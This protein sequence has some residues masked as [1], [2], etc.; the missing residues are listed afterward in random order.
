MNS[1]TKIG[2]LTATAG[3]ALAMSSMAMAPGTASATRPSQG[4]HTVTICHRTNSVTNPYVVITVDEA[5][6]NKDAGDDRG[7]GDHNA[8]H[9]GPAFDPT[10]TYTPP[11]RGDEWGDIIPPFYSDGTTTG[12]WE[13]KNWPS[14]QAIFEN[15]CAPVIPTTTTAAPTSTTAAPTTTTD[16][17][18]DECEH[19]GDE[20]DEDDE[21]DEGDDCEEVTTTTAA[22]TTTTEAPT[23]TTEAPTTTVDAGGPT[24]TEAPT[25]PVEATTTTIVG[26]EGPTTTTLL[27]SEGPATTALASNGGSLPATGSSQTILVVLG[28]GMVL[29]GLVFLALTRRPDEL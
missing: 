19:S 6:V 25:T 5:A 14:G 15:G 28:L 3:A 12:Y 26:S 21:G 27:G 9:N 22:P 2:M 4:V 29:G 18:T 20:D 10:A 16:G 1:R 24:T 11:M 7:Q 17:E 23:S 8:Q 13:S